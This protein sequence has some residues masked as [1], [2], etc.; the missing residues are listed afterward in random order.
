MFNELKEDVN[1]VIKPMYEQNGNFD[2]ETENL[3][4]S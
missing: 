3:K 2:K 1:K 4:I